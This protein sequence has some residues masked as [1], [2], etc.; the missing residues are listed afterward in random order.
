VRESVSSDLA[1]AI[2]SAI[3]A[4][5]GLRSRALGLVGPKGSKQLLNQMEAAETTTPDP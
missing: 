2:T 5:R 3:E 1:P 4:S